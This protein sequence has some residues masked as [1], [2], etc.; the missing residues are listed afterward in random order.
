MVGSKDIEI[1]KATR[2]N[3]EELFS[4]AENFWNESNFNNGSLTLA[5]DFWKSTVSHHI[6]LHD[7]AAI[8]AK[9]DGAIVGYVL[10]YYQTDYTKEKIGEMFQFYVKPEMRGT[11]VARSLVSSAVEQYEEW[12][13]KRAYCEASPGISH[14]DHLGMFSNLWAKYGYSEIGVTLMKE[15]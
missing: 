13:C 7:T 1:F 10:I 2:D 11:P 6:G 12:G 3:L 9:V 5:P 15:F 4:L 8:C 14:R